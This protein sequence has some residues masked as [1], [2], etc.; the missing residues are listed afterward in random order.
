METV[1]VLW[2]CRERDEGEDTELLIGVYRAEADAKGAID[3]LKDKRGFVDH[4]DGFEI[5]PY[6]LGK[7]HWT[8]GF[9]TETF[10]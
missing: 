10:D 7:D 2:Y 9:I 3:R 1:Y 4:P 8:D 6:E 5:V